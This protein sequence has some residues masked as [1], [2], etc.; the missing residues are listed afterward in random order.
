MRR[1]CA[2]WAARRD[3]VLARAGGTVPEPIKE[4]L[5]RYSP[6]LWPDTTCESSR[7]EEPTVDQE[8]GKDSPAANEAASIKPGLTARELQ[9]LRSLADGRTDQQIAAL[10]TLSHKTIGHHVGRIMVKLDANNR[11]HAVAIA[12]RRSLIKL[13]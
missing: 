1:L 5:R 4:M 2:E 9:V 12:V 8:Q 6:L 3:A 11:A 7:L 13:D 10:L